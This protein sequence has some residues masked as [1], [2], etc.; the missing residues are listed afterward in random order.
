[1]FGDKLLSLPLDCFSDG[2]DFYV[3]P[4]TLLTGEH[5]GE[6]M[7]IK[8]IKRQIEIALSKEDYEEANRLNKLLN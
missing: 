3:D 2:W 4:L 6:S 8:E 1:M 5:V 7:D